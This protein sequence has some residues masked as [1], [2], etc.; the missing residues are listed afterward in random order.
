MNFNGI[1]VGAATFLIIGLCHPLVIKMEYYWGKKSWWLLFL[2]EFAFLYCHY[3]YLRMCF[4]Q[5]LELRLSL[6]FGV[7]S[8]Y[9][10]KRKESLKGGFL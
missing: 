6:V 2:P 4:L 8:K 3:G 10:N 1:I 5:S 7:L 9:S